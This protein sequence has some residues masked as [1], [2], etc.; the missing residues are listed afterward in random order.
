M[1]LDALV[2]AKGTGSSSNDGSS[3]SS[4]SSSGDGSGGGGLYTS[5]NVKPYTPLESAA[6]R[7]LCG[8]IPLLQHKH[9][10]SKLGA[11]AS[12]NRILRLTRD[13]LCLVLIESVEGSG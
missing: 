10:V 9:R 5:S 7:C 6:R 8:G 13:G 12:R 2:V 3:S 4:S 1:E 11:L